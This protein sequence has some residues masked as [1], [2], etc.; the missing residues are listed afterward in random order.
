MHKL[1][2]PLEVEAP[3]EEAQF[4]KFKFVVWQDII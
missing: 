3:E 2:E 4:E 1:Q